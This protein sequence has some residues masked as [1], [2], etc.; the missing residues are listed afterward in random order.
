MHHA[1]SAIL[2]HVAPTQFLTLMCPPATRSLPA[3]PFSSTGKD[4]PKDIDVVMVA[5]KGMGPN[6]HL[7]PT[8]TLN[9]IARSPPLIPPLIFLQARTSPRTSTW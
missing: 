7:Y 2:V 1:C 9:F 5:P 8:P 3:F 4:L 6:R